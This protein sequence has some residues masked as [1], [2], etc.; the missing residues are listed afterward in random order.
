M[1]E[2][3]PTVEAAT[4]A[5]LPRLL[6]EAACREL[7]LRAAALADA[8]QAEAL[9]ALFTT[10]AR[11]TRPGGLLLQGRDAIARTYRERAPHRLTSHLVCGTLFD[12]LTGEEARATSRVLLWSGDGR[13]EVGP[14][15]RPAD[16]RQVVGRFEDRFV[17]TPEGWR[18]AERVACFDLHTPQV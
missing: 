11:L 2:A 14:Y 7:V 10:D 5:L 17:N 4:R 13:S 1:P 12:S 16:P 15:G 18:I 9:A 8:G 6:A 3:D